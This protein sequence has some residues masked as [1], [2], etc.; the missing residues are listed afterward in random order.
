MKELPKLKPTITLPDE[1]AER[2]GA[3]SASPDGYKDVLDAIE[4]AEQ[5]VIALCTGKEKWTMRVPVDEERDSDCLIMRALTK[6][7]ETIG[8]W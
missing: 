7:R 1:F 3:P 4:K 2:Y 8:S 6:A 5:H